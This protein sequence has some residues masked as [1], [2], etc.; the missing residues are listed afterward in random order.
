[1]LLY[2]LTAICY[3]RDTFQMTVFVSGLEMKY[4]HIS[5]R[6]KSQSHTV[7]LD[8]IPLYCM[9][10]VFQ[11]DRIQLCYTIMPASLGHELIFAAQR[12]AI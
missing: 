6:M 8:R 11:E 9:C 10:T 12:M 2:L 4:L 1:M 3:V 7:S 5:S